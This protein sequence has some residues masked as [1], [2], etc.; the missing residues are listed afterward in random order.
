MPYQRPL[1]LHA[2]GAII[3]KTFYISIK[4]S[5]QSRKVRKESSFRYVLTAG[6]GVDMR[7]AAMDTNQPTE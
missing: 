1:V 3:F 4:Y 6:I 7:Q 2:I 5:P